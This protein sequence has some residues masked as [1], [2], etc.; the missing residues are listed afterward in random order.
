MKI[1][2]VICQLLRVPSVEQK[3]ASSQD[4]VLVRIRT[5]TGLEGIGE[6]DSQPEVVKAIIDAPFSHN[7]ACGL[8]QLL[9]GENPLETERLWQKMY[10]RTM[11]FGR[12]SVTITAM[13][14]IDMALWDLKGKLYDQPIHRLLGGKQHDRIKA[15]ASILFGRDGAETK[16]IAERWRAAGYRAI[17][18]GWEPM[19]QSE[20]LDIE[21]V[22]GAR[23]GIGDGILLID[24]GCVW[25]ARTALQRAEAFKEYRLGWLEEPLRPDDV[26]GYRWL[27]D[28]SPIPIAGGEEECG[29]E[30]WRP[31]IEARALDIYQVDL[32]RNGFTEA[33][34]VKQRVQEI[35]ARLCNHCYTSPVTVAASLHWLTTCRD[36]FVFEDCVD[37]SPLR[38]ELTHERVQAVDGWITPPDGPGLGV[39]LNEDFVS[40]YL[41]AESGRV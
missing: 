10:R 7:I 2:E 24:A 5:D 40:S 29:R 20:A 3:T 37:D 32:A 12:S 4:A 31:L 22:Q 39:T 16:A 15:Y 28:R 34:Y 14:A 38:H 30:A 33:D 36:A 23:Q 35:G 13:A 17:K 26:E 21:L 41:I 9:I 6:A 25:D 8:R 11:Y 1:T 18:F 27:R 19:G